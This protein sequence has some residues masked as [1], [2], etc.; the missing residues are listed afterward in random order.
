MA[1]ARII[2]QKQAVVAEIKEKFDI[3]L[4]VEA[5]H[6]GLECGVFCGKEPEMDIICFG[7]KG[8]G[9]HTPEE[10]LDIKSFGEMYDYLVYFLEELTKE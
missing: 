10:W 6:G 3:D 5:T 7:P 2:E 1:N 9:A 8:D 4:H